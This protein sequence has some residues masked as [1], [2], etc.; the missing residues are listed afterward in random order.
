LKT[1]GVETMFVHDPD[2]DRA[3]VLADEVGAETV[4][5]AEAAYERGA[6]AVLVCSP[7]SMHLAQAAGA[8]AGGCD[9]FVEK[10]L[11]STLDGVDE[12]VAEAEK[13]RRLVMVG[14]NLRFNECLRTVKSW[15]DNGRIGRLVSSRFYYGGY[16]PTRHPDEDY[17]IGY[18]ARAELGGG[19]ILDTIHEIDAALWLAGEPAS[20]YC[21]AGHFSKLEIDTEDVAEIVLKT[22]DGGVASIHLDYL[23]QPTRRR[24]DLIGDEGTITCDLVAGSAALDGVEGSDSF[25]DRSELNDSYVRELAL[26]L[27][28]VS[29]REAV[30]VDAREARRSLAVALA[31]KTSAARGEPIEVAL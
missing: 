2:E 8:V 29:T 21:V 27:R 20:V 4:R 17:R 6:T 11:A 26:F 12:L 22:R 14:Y 13:R 5:S 24:Y 30:P 31:A 23:T 15:L 28:A 10:P 18:G 1:L 16:L 3:R 7:T 19:T 9:V 25:T